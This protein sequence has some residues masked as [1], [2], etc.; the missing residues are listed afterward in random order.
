MGSWALDLGP[1][2]LVLTETLRFQWFEKLFRRACGSWIWSVG[3]SHFENVDIPVVLKLF[4]SKGLG[5][6]GFGPWTLDFCIH[7]NVNISLVLIAF[8]KGMR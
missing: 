8:S 3:L 4:L 6:L 7:R 1:W 2:T 5:T